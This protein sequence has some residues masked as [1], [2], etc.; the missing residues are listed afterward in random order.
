MYIPVCIDYDKAFDKVQ[1]EGIV[2]AVNKHHVVIVLILKSKIANY[3][4]CLHG[5]NQLKNTTLQSIQ[6][7]HS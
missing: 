2:Q 4:N 5:F 1:A 7:K 3:H 6:N